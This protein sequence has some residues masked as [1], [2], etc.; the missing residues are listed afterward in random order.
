MA[1]VLIG[2]WFGDRV[3]PE[4]LDAW[5]WAAIVITTILATGYIGWV[6]RKAVEPPGAQGPVEEA[7]P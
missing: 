5:T 6:A 7:T 4:G 3:R 2:A 1:Y